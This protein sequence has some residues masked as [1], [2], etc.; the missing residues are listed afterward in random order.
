MIGNK[1]NL[2]YDSGATPI[3]A[4]G[5]SYTFSFNF[6]IPNNIAIGSH[7]YKVVWIDKGILLGSVV[8]KTGSFYLHDAYEKVYLGLQ[9]TVAAKLNQQINANYKSPDA[10]SLLNQAQSAYQ[11]AGTLANQGKFQDASNDMTTAS[12]LLDQAAAAEKS[13]VSNPSTLGGNPQLWYIV[14][15]GIVI[16]IVTVLVIIR[17]GKSSK[18]DVLIKT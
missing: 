16:I 3:I 7:S 13:Y 9:P 17:R 1:L 12:N 10:Q 11:L 8:V 4:S 14:I 15:I 18:S 5:S 2:V 6:N